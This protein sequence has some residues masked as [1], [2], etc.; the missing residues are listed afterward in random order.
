MS[1]ETWI[2]GCVWFSGISVGI[3]IMTVLG[4]LL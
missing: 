4:V 3:A 1:G 2:L